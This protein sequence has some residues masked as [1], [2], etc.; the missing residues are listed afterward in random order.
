MASTPT[1]D[2]N[3]IIKKPNKEYW[4]SIL[5]NSLSPLT[6]RSLQGL[7]S[8]GSTFKM[9]VA[10]AAGQQPRLTLNPLVP[11]E[12]I[13]A[14]IVQVSLGDVQHDSLE[15]RT[16]FA[17]GITLFVFTFILNNISFWI[18]KKFREEYD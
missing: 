5:S 15:Y 18:R 2:P 4:D 13:T 9:I 10:I 7:Y 12:T 17:A 1:Y 6:N 3:K 8:P 16:I 14:Y 11:V